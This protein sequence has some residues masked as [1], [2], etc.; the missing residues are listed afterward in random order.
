M[1]FTGTATPLNAADVET[2][3]HA[4]TVEVAAVWAVTD[5]ESAGAGFLPDRRPK[6]LFEAQVFGQLSGHKWDASHPNV[7]ARHWDRTL[8]GPGG[9]HQYDRLAEA[10][11][12]DETMALEAASWG[13][14]QVLGLNYPRC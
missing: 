10:A 12:L 8:Y 14:F 11:A 3:A 1:N 9:A 2:A 13:M 7:S 4:M 6:I 5:V